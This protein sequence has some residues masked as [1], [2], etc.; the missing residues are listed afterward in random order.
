MEFKE[1]KRGLSR[2]LIILL[3]ILS[4]LVSVGILFIAIKTFITNSPVPLSNSINLKIEKVQIV[5]NN[6]TLLLKRNAGIGEF[7]G[8]N[9]VLNDGEKSE[10]FDENVFIEELGAKTFMFTLVKINPDNLQNIKI[11]PIIELKSGRKVKSDIEYIWE[12]SSGIYRCIPDCNNKI[13]G[14]DG[15]GRSCGKCPEGEVCSLGACVDS[16]RDTCFS[17]KHE[18]D[19]VCGKNCGS[20]FNPHGLNVCLN[21]LCQPN[22][23]IG[24]GDCDKNRTNGCEAQLGTDLNCASCGNACPEGKACIKG[25]CDIPC[26]DTCTSLN[27][28]CGV[29]IICGNKVLCGIC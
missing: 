2:I 5:E 21:G 1:D 29:H 7:V 24:Y 9:F 13:C 10:T 22:C 17:L 3:V 18:C 25:I 26:I 20:C 6:L 27:Y 8:L 15:C 28:S 14:D 16:C 4:F 11:T 19:E 12:S 23:S